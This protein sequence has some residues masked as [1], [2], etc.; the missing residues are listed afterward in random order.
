MSIGRPT[1]VVDTTILENYKTL[2]NGEELLST[3]PISAMIDLAILEGLL[4]VIHW[5]EDIDSNQR[6]L[7]QRFPGYEIAQGSVGLFQLCIPQS[8]MVG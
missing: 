8:C 3:V 7:V 5:D 6:G 1:A 4:V 2:A